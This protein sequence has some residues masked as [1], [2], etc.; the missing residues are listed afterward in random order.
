MR[1]A[2]RIIENRLAGLHD[3]ITG[4]ISPDICGEISPALRGD[5]SGLRGDVSGLRG[6]VD[7]CELTDEDRKKGVH[8]DDLVEVAR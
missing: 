2:L 7:A 4:N 6:D 5:I 3:G 1:R 8:V